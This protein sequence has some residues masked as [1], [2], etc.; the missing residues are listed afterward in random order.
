MKLL[1]RLSLGT[2]LALAPALAVVIIAAFA[3]YEVALLGDLRAEVEALG[4]VPIY[5]S[6]SAQVV[7][8]VIAAVVAAVLCVLVF[9]LLRSAVLRPAKPVIASLFTASRQLLGAADQLAVASQELASGASEQAAGLEETSS[10]LEEMAAVAHQNLD[11]NKHARDESRDG[12]AVA[13]DVAAAIEEI[14]GAM[15]SIRQSSEATARIIKTI[16]EIA[17]QTNLLALNAAVEAARAGE[18]GKGFAVVA[19][20]VRNLAQRSAEAARST[21]DMIEESQSNAARG[22]AVAERASAMF[23][24]IKVVAPRIHELVVAGSTAADEHAQGIMQ[25]NQA[26]AQLDAVTQ[27]NAA[28]AEETASAG[29]EL[30]AQARELDH[31]TRSLAVVVEGSNRAAQHKSVEQASP[32][33]A[34]AGRAGGA[35]T[36]S[37]ATVSRPGGNGRVHPTPEQVIPL[38][39]ADLEDF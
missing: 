30:S 5:D 23:E 35:H 10:S 9:F 17:F 19:E 1:D 39:T 32:V 38:E 14:S 28:I 33:F 15:N 16:D 4:A 21:A 2:K 29:E 34:T 27:S 3:A 37:R 6:I 26:I 20:E 12:A 31:I 13:Q 24:K 7:G 36:S 25:L 22:V 18:A 8:T 11:M